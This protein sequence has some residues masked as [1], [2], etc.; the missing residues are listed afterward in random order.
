MKLSRIKASGI[1]NGDFDHIL[2]PFTVLIGDNAAGKTKVLNAAAALLL[3]YVPSLGKSH[4]A[5][6]Q[7]ANGP[8]LLIEGWT[9][10]GVH[11]W[12]KWRLR[13]DSV[14]RES[15]VPKELEEF[16]GL[17]VMLDASKYFALPEA[18]R[19]AYIAA[20][21]PARGAIAIA[22][23]AVRL[24]AQIGEHDKDRV[25]LFLEALRQKTSGIAYPNTQAYVDDAIDIVTDLRDS[26]KANATRAEK[27]IQ[28][29]TDM[30]V[31]DQPATPLSVL[32]D[33]KARIARELATLNE[34][35]GRLVSAMDQV[36][37]DNER[38]RVIDRDLGAMDK[39]LGDVETQRTKLNLA[40]EQLGQTQEVTRAEI[41]GA[42]DAKTAAANAVSEARRLA[43][44]ATEKEFLAERQ[45]A[46]LDHQDTCP[47]CGASG[48]GWKAIKAAEL[49]QAID[50]AD[51]AV[52]NQKANAQVA[53]E[54]Y[55]AATRRYNA[56]LDEFNR[57]E[58]L[59]STQRQAQ[60]A[61]LKLDAIVARAKALREERGRLMAAD[62]Q[63]AAEINEVQGQINVLN[64]DGRA[65]DRQI[66]EANGRAFEVKRLADAEKERDDAKQDAEIAAAALKEL[67]VIQAELVA[68]V[69][70]PLLEVANNFYVP[71]FGARL[72]YHN[73]ELGRWEDGQW[74][75]HK[76]FSG[77]ERLLAYCSIQ[78][79]L[80]A[81]S[82]LKLFLTDEL[83]A[84]HS[85]RLPT[86]I[87]V[88]R[89]AVR[90]GVI[91]TVIGTEPERGEIYR[92]HAD[93]DLQLIEVS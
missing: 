22:D 85:K 90:D 31:K 61:L 88:M 52:T 87:E 91:D 69:F 59:V 9:D 76:T 24:S 13:G 15:Q 72:G 38:R 28:Q 20:H 27:T 3:G 7:L 51:Q 86:F 34:R 65:L 46:D 6:F 73:N 12:R 50:Q 14:T 54:Q 93:S 62:P 5:T 33:G 49:A 26:A 81:M 77:G 1:Q 10:T 37:K 8:E 55:E 56:L 23:V 75:T 71:V 47:Y 45:L 30:R 48:D 84:I 67:K 53:Q 74:V 89:A 16:D 32:E 44:D 83:K 63:L 19:V 92:Q 60:D 11:L 79:A 4:A 35:R 29:L 66:Q 40:T 25:G 64:D 39:Q 70:K 18:K 43:A 58:Q 57:R 80:S 68:E 42:R 41:D 36:A 82:P 78:A 17:E 2:L 21:C